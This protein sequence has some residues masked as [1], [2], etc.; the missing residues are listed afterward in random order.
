MMSTGSTSAAAANAVASAPDRLAPSALPSSDDGAYG[1][2]LDS[3]ARDVLLDDDQS[4]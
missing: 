3:L 2:A 4:F 1:R